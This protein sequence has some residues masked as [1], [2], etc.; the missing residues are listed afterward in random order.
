MAIQVSGTEV[1]SNSRALNNIASV[2]ATTATAIGAAGVGGSTVYLGETLIT[3]NI[4]YVQY[5]FPAGYQRFVFQI[6]G[7]EGQIERRNF[8]CRLTDSSNNILSSSTSYWS[9]NTTDDASFSSDSKIL[10]GKVAEAGDLAPRTNGVVTIESPLAT[11]IGTGI[12]VNGI[13]TSNN[14]ATVMSR[15]GYMRSVAKNNGV[16]FRL[17]AG[18][19]SSASHGYKVWGIK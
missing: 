18:N 3:S 13:Y 10:M 11:D 8:W 15:R 12:F 6:I 16:I 14:T 2:D 1:I 9:G 7:W 19:I 17:D 5:N 4:S